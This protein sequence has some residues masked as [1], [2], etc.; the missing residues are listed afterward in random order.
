LATASK[1]NLEGA[2]EDIFPKNDCFGGKESVEGI[3]VFSDLKL[4]TINI[5]SDWVLLKSPFYLWS[6][7][8]P[9]FS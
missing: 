6:E 9:V 1:G 5:P 3:N 7:S 4:K 8:K 2:F